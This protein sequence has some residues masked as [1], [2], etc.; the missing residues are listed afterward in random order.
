MNLSCFSLRPDN[1]DLNQK[2][3]SLMFCL[4][5]MKGDDVDERASLVE[6]L[7]KAFLSDYQANSTR[8]HQ[9]S[10]QKALVDRR[11]ARVRCTRI[12]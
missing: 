2:S 8:A 12:I 5:K 1:D 3:K 10:F 11:R 9:A 7:D 6:E 4:E